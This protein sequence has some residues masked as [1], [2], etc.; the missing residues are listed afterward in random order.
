MSRRLDRLG[1]GAALS[2]LTALLAASSLAAP[3]P[4]RAECL[5][6]DPWPS[7]RSAFPSAERVIVGEVVDD[8]DPDSS[9]HLAVFGL[10]VDQ[11]LR[12]ATPSEGVIEVAYLRSGLPPKVCPSGS[13][14]LVLLGDVIVLAFDARAASGERINTLAYIRGTPD[15]FLMPG[16]EA[17]SLA[18]LQE[19]V[20]NAGPA[21]NAGPASA[22]AIAALA[23]V[24]MLAVGM[25][26]LVSRFVRR[27]AS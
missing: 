13:T 2:F 23:I 27:G 9:G 8:R 14:A 24:V 6:T 20:R 22:L 5:R 26:L 12:G 7:F 16:V 11:V 15:D 1:R 4:A 19:I 21:Q 17:I 3:G 10:R 25:T 18:E